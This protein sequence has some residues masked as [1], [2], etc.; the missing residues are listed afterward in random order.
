M[1]LERLK[2]IKKDTDYPGEC[3]EMDM[4]QV[5]GGPVV[6]AAPKKKSMKKYH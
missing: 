4:S 1:E 3:F 2:N 6:L 5:L